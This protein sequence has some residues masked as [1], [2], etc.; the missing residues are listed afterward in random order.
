MACLKRWYKTAVQ[1]YQ[2]EPGD[3]EGTF[4]NDPV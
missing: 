3:A 2:V 1:C 4:S